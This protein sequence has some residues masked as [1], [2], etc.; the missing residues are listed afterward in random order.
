[1]AAPPLTE[2][3]RKANEL[4]AQIEENLSELRRLVKAGQRA[5]RKLEAARAHLNGASA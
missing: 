4:I 3:E 1:M 5:E 2:T